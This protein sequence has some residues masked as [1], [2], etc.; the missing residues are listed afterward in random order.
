MAEMMHMGNDNY[1]WTA[2]AELI[3]YYEMG[4]GIEGIAARRK[5]KVKM[6]A[7]L[8]TISHGFSG[9]SNSR[10]GFGL[11]GGL[12]EISTLLM[13]ERQGAAVA[14]IDRDGKL[15]W[16]ASNDLKSDFAEG[17]E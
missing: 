7:V 15:A 10:F 17:G 4:K 13:L 14:E 6:D 3:L 12:T 2:T 9:L 1:I 8:K 11:A 5:Q 16:R